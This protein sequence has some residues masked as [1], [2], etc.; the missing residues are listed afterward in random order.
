MAAF[1]G[2]GGGFL[3]V[4]LLLVFTNFTAQKAVGTS[5]FAILFISISAIFCHNKLNN[6]EYQTAIL[7]GIGG[8]LGAP[9][10]AKL[11]N[12]ISTL[13]FKKVFAIM[14]IGLGIM[15]LFKK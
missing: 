1:L 13:H 12:S 2:V 11:V 4:P 8:I 9:I 10:G 5:L 14:L 7:L 3:M 6:I 15:L